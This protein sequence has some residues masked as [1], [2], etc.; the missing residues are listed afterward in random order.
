[1]R[2]MSNAIFPALCPLARLRAMR[3]MPQGVIGGARTHIETQQEVVMSKQYEIKRLLD[4]A[5]G[6]DRAAL[7]KRRRAGRELAALQAEFPECWR[8]IAR[9]DATTAD[10]LLSMARGK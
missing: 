5:H 2:A 10:K 3:A 7:A 8:Q 1:M 6:H 9:L 4:E